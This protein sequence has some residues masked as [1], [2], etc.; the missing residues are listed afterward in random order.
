MQPSKKFTVRVAIYSIGLLYLAG[1]LFLFNG[2]VNRHIQSSRPDS[3]EAFAAAREQGVV[4]RVMGKPVYL[5]Q[6]ER[7]AR[8]RLWL[9]GRDIADLEP[10][11]RRTERLAALNELIDHEILRT[12]VLHNMDSVPVADDEIDDA[13]KRLA[14]RFA[15]RDEMRRELAAEGID[16][17]KELRYRLAARLQQQ[18][19]IESRIGEHISID[20]AEARAWFERHRPEFAQPARVRARHVF[21]AT[22][23]REPEDARATLDDALAGLKAGTKSFEDLAASLSDDLRTKDGGGDLGWMTE[24]R[25]PADFGKP[26]FRMAKGERRLLRT[27]LGW[28]LV[29]VTDTRPPE[30][31][32]FEEARD[33]VV[34]ALES[35]RRIEMVAELRK[36]LRGTDGIGVHV[37]NDM[38][39]GE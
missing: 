31:R 25:L 5:S 26:L 18:K 9:R 12:K 13:V 22:L 39:T 34:A 27:K 10:A 6:V 16:S 1:D 11:Q 24:A 28:H 7:A 30:E 23:D 35:A 2:P 38:I 20:E 19:Y 32:T 14:S 33:E 21:L 15:S 37:F 8:E 4:A 36:T 29:E 17:E 3:D